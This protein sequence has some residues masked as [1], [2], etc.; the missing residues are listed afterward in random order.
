MSADEEFLHDLLE[1]AAFPRLMRDAVERVD[2]ALSHLR[3]LTAQA[4]MIHG[5]FTRARPTELIQAAV[6]M[7]R[8]TTYA[9]L[10]TRQLLSLVDDKA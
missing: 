4:D 1:P 3:G 6:A 2:C 5:C 8:Q 10:H 7:E 9:Q